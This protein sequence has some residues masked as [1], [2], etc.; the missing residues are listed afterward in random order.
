M[1]DNEKI[2]EKIRKAVEDEGAELR[3]SFVAFLKDDQMTFVT[4]VNKGEVHTIVGMLE[5]AKLQ[6]LKRIEELNE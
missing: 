6:L 3:Y 1:I 4:Q 2:K 5:R